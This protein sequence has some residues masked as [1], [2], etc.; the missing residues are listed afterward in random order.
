MRLRKWESIGHF[1]SAAAKWRRSYCS[2]QCNLLWYLWSKWPNL[3]GVYGAGE[4]LLSAENGSRA[5]ASFVCSNLWK[6]FRVSTSYRTFHVLKYPRLVEFLFHVHTSRPELTRIGFRCLWTRAIELVI[7]FDAIRM[8]MPN[9]S[10]SLLMNVSQLRD[11]FSSSWC[12][13]KH[14]NTSKNTQFPE[15][16]HM[17][18]STRN[19]RTRTHLTGGVVLASAPSGYYQHV[20]SPLPSPFRRGDNIARQCGLMRM[21]LGLI[22]V[23]PKPFQYPLHYPSRNN[24]AHILLHSTNWNP[25]GPARP[26]ISIEEVRFTSGVWIDD[27]GTFHLTE[28]PGIPTYVGPPS[29]DID[30]HWDSII[31]R[32]LY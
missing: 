18:R 16:L 29:P 27:N 5:D 28:H 13:R 30:K 2:Q 24:L 15:A 3:A 21:D 7:Q 10:F 12:S 1:S 26:S 20:L 32:E 17:T 11:T 8:P 6:A 14:P 22:L 31:K 4:S 23:R 19:L 9:E 25:I